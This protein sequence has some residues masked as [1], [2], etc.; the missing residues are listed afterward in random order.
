ME[1]A[2][3]SR[4]VINVDAWRK[5][6]KNEVEWTGYEGRAHRPA[7]AL[8]QKAPIMTEYPMRHRN[9]PARRTDTTKTPPR[10]VEHPTPK[11]STTQGKR[12]ASGPLRAR[13]SL[14][15]V[16]LREVLRYPVRE[17]TLVKLGGEV[18]VVERGVDLSGKDLSGVDLRRADLREAD[19]RG[20]NLTRAVLQGA[21]LNEAKLQ[22]AIL[23]K[24]DFRDADLRGVKADPGSLRRAR[25]D[26]ALLDN[27]L[28]SD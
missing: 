1:E 27:N 11:A 2:V 21:K 13:L 25:L 9:R 7:L 6:P 16:F 12:A 5:D 20:T 18:L 22:G 24:T 4:R 26:G 23:E 15:P 3:E 17:F 28:L 10:P 14:V 19:L 8:E